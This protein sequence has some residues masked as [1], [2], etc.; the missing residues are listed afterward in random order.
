M[1]RVIEF[2]LCGSE[3]HRFDQERY[4]DDGEPLADEK[5][6]VLAPFDPELIYAEDKVMKLS[7]W[8]SGY[9]GV[10]KKLPNDRVLCDL[11]GVGRL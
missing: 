5:G 7:A 10:G 6:N 4:D 1:Y 11:S 2:E 8:V 3:K 9:L